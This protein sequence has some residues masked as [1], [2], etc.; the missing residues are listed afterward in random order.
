MS[1]LLCFSGQ[2]ASGKS[3]VSIAVA[4]ALGWH[5]TG[6]GDFLRSEIARLGGN[7]GD[8]EA[9]QNFGQ[10]RVDDDPVAFCRD[11]LRAGGFVPGEDFVIDGIRHAS[12]FEILTEVS[13]PSRTRLLFLGASET[14]RLARAEERVDAS[15][16]ARASAHRVEAE[17]INA[18]P[19]RADGIVNS[20]QSLDCVVSDCLDLVKQWTQDRS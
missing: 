14:T 7:P 5:R 19:Q 13:A 12:I 8:R 1:M 16:F 3:S 9:L 20:D 6:F 15:D 18:L 10:K 2:I 17:L 4:E 11:V